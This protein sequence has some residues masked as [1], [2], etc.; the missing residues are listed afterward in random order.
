MIKHYDDEFE[1]SR[2][3]DKVV[4]LEKLKPNRKKVLVYSPKLKANILVYKS[5]LR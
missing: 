4:L 3:V 1:G 2:L 5:R